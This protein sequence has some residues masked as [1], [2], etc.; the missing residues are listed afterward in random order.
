MISSDTY[1]ELAF[2]TLAHADQNYFIHQHLVDAHIAQT[3]DANTKQI[4]LVFALVGLYLAVEKG[5]TG[6]EV[7][8][9]HMQLAKN[10][11]SLPDINLPVKRG[12]ITATDVL[13]TE[14]GEDRDRMIKAWCVSVWE[15]Y[16]DSQKAI[17]QY[18]S[19]R[20]VL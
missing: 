2:Y 5:Y 9:A 15:A 10:K 20:L 18:I 17:V 4:S 1:N 12:D 8:Q 16:K 14:A 6:K 3:A 7:Q 19:E 11:N 13:K